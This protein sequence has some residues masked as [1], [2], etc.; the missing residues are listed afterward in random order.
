MALRDGLPERPA[1]A[2]PTRDSRIEAMMAYRD[3]VNRKPMDALEAAQGGLS[4]VPAPAPPNQGV[5]PNM[6]IPPNQ[7]MRPNMPI[8]P[9][10]GRRPN[11]PVFVPD[12]KQNLNEMLTATTQ[13][14]DSLAA[15]A[16]EALSN[17]AKLN[18]IEMAELEDSDPEMFAA[19]AGGGLMQ[20]AAGGEF[21]GRVPGD[22]HGMQDN[23]FMPIAEGNEQVATLAVSP[24]E[25]VVDSYTMAALGNGNAEEGADVMDEAIKQ[26]RQKAYG[27]E[28]QPNEMQGLSAL[29]PLIERV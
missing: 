5:Q 9:N 10:Q 18:L 13:D 7:G 25:Y 6:P 22:G 29:R 3:D 20:L 24:S 28:E 12:V 15:K 4:Q 14:G 21:S 1:E 19:K 27:S 17:K 26:I 16:L 23:V 8:P 11:M 2:V